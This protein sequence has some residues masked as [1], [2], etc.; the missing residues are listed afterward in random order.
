MLINRIKRVMARL[1]LGLMLGVSLIVFCFIFIYTL[2]FPYYYLPLPKYW[3]VEK[4]GFQEILE[5]DDFT[6]YYVDKMDAGGYDKADVRYSALYQ[7]YRSSEKDSYVNIS[8]LIGLSRY[9]EEIDDAIV[10]QKYL[11]D[12]HLYFENR[13]YDYMCG[14]AHHIS[15]IAAGYADNMKARGNYDEAFYTL[16]KLTQSRKNDLNPWVRFSNLENV[17][18]LL[19]VMPFGQSEL[20]FFDSELFELKA[21]KTNEKL[22]ARYENLLVWR[23]DLYRSYGK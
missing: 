1:M 22:E 15:S 8:A 17:Y 20:Q 6:L 12:H 5:P 4:I 13:C 7:A 2:K 9:V 19:D 11:L 14:S 10:I 16:E 23:E 21:I 18:F 3:S